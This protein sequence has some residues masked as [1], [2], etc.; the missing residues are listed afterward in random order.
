MAAATNVL[1]APVQ[2]MLD[3]GTK[4]LR[5]V[6]SKAG[7]KGVGP[8][9]T[10]T[11]EVGYLMAAVRLA[12]ESLGISGDVAEKRLQD[13]RLRGLTRIAEL[14]KAAEPVLETGEVCALLGVSRE[15]IRKKVDRKQ[16][17][18]LPKGGDRV[19]PAFQF[20]D[21]DVHPGFAEVLAALDTDSPFVAL[22]FLLSKSPSFGG[23]SA[24]ELV[25]CGEL[26]PVVAEARGFL[27]HGA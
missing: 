20:K 5:T 6:L 11:N 2:Q 14:R 19:F 15:T 17:L 24:Y 4:T 7:P 16:L 26:E 1:E 3:R 23:K 27:N 9:Q 13:A 21:G 10:S 22:S 8:L 12:I 18:A 25:Q